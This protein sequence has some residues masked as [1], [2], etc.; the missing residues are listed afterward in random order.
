MPRHHDTVLLNFSSNLKFTEFSVLVMEYLGNLLQIDDER[1]FQIEIALREVINN[2]IVHGNR[3][4]PKKRVDVRFS[5]NPDFLR[6]RIRDENP[7]KVDFERITR[8]AGE[9]DVLSPSGRGMLLMQNYMDSLS[10][11]STATGSVIT[12][13]KRL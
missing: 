8:E 1:F 9:K 6:I 3:S 2:A 4:N 11:E 5:W 7:E 10:F 13:E 12:M